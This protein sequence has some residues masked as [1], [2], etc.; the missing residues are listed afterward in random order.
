MI[1]ELRNEYA[2]KAEIIGLT[3]WIGKLEAAE[4]DFEELF[5]LRNTQLAGNKKLSIKEINK[6]II[7]IY[8]RMIAR[9]NA[10]LI[11]NP[12]PVLL[13]FAGELNK[14]INYANQH[15]DH[16]KTK[17]SIENIIVKP[18]EP[19]TETGNP[20]TYM[21]KLSIEIKGKQ[22]ELFF[23]VDYTLR[24]KNNTKPGIAEIIIYGKGK[25]KGKKIVTF[26]I[27][28]NYKLNN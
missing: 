13:E 10:A 23:S 1:Y 22:T 4:A 15:G 26:N 16:R 9:L 5:K 14:Q 17:T 3:P 21:P 8:R 25:F 6:L 20:I 27:E 18:I 7:P 24:Y 28:K 19:Q 12:T 11:L 2:E